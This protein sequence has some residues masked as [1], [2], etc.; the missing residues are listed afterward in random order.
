MS[1]LVLTNENLIDLSC[2]GI[3]CLNLLNFFHIG[4]PENG[5]AREWWRSFI[6]AQL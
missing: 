6:C 5:N 4:S 1:Q 2:D 3:F